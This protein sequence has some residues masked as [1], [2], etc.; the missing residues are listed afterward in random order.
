MDKGGGLNE[1]REALVSI[2]R[3]REL[4][5]RLEDPRGLSGCE[6]LIPIGFVGYGTLLSHLS[7]RDHIS[8]G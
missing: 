5:R 4:E 1:P 6:N 2:Q 3:G 7:G 8:E